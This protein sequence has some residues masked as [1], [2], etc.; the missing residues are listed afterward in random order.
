MKGCARTS[1]RAREPEYEAL[2]EIIR[3]VEQMGQSGACDPLPNRGGLNSAFVRRVKA[4]DARWRAGT[5]R[6]NSGPLPMSPSI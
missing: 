5:G 2:G 1:R 3:L 4:I 6:T